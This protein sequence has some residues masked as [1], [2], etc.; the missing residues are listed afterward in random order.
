MIKILFPIWAIKFI[1]PR[2][3]VDN[4]SG[5]SACLTMSCIFGLFAHLT[6]EPK[7]EKSFP[8]TSNCNIDAL[9]FKCIQIK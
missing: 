2:I 9:T 5:K 8:H 4:V 6:I 7:Q 3:K 1:H